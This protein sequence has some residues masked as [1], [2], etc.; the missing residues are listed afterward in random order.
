MV[1]SLDDFATWL[2]ARVGEA[3][4]NGRFLVVGYC[5]APNNERGIT[6]LVTARRFFG[7]VGRLFGEEYPDQHLSLGRPQYLDLE[8]LEK[9]ALL[10]Q[11]SLRSRAQSLVE[12]LE[13]KMMALKVPGGSTLA[14]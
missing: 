13:M 9:Q 3:T 12:L 4:D 5:Y 1:L 7:E 8:P 10:E 2:R 6:L 11:R 14:H